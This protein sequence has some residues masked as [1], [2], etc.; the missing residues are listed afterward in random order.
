MPRK[1][2]D[3]LDKINARY[4][5]HSENPRV[6][7]WLKLFWIVVFFGFICMLLEFTLGQA[8]IWTYANTYRVAIPWLYAVLLP[9]CAIFWFRI[10][11][12]HRR[13]LNF[14]TR[15]I[16]DRIILFSLTF[17]YSSAFVICIPLG[18]A[19]LAG[20]VLGTPSDQI[21]AKVL[22]VSP[23]SNSSHS[24]CRQT[25]KINVN[26]KDATICIINRVVGFNPVAGDSITV[27]G[28]VSIF[29]VLVEKIRVK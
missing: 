28:K 15:T 16:L 1:V 3:T 8:F 6:D 4:A 5:I 21:P 17:I 10:E 27:Q 18:L 22:S 19:A 13:Y 2:T 11:K 7:L 24:F 26:G 9:V 20:W 12:Q 29:G 23:L 25:A 14:G